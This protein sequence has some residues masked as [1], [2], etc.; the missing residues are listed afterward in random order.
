MN[1]GP[2][3]EGSFNN[4]EI[5][6]LMQEQSDISQTTQLVQQQKQQ[7]T[8]TSSDPAVDIKKVFSKN[9]RLGPLILFS[10]TYCLYSR[11]L[12]ALLSENFELTPQVVIIEL[13]QYPNGG[14]L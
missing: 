6:S 14:E 13:N 7:D 12:K 2:L 1:N 4:N 9:L 11:N 10:K 3:K 5:S 8:E